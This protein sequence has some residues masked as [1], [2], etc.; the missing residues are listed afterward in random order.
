MKVDGERK[1]VTSTF[2]CLDIYPPDPLKLK[3]QTNKHVVLK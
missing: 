3:G 1:I 2:L